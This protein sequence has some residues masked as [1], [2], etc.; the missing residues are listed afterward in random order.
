MR[1]TISTTFAYYLPI[2]AILLGVLSPPVAVG[3]SMTIEINDYGPTREEAERRVLLNAVR[4]GL[5]RFMNEQAKHPSMTERILKRLNAI[6]ADHY[7]PLVKRW[8]LDL[9]DANQGQHYLEGKVTL[10]VD[11]LKLWA[12][13]WLRQLSA[14]GKT[15]RA[16]IKHRL[17]LFIA[18]EALEEADLAAE[19]RALRKP[20]MH[21]LEQRLI[22]SGYEIKREEQKRQAQYVL[23]LSQSSLDRHGLSGSVNFTVEVFENRADGSLVTTADGYAAASLTTTSAALRKELLQR[24]AV[25]VAA[26]L[27]RKFEHLAV[28]KQTVELVFFAPQDISKRRA[29]HDLLEGLA[30][31]YGLTS[32]A[33]IDT[34]DEAVNLQI[35]EESDHYTFSFLVPD[36][37]HVRPTQL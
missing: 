20:F 2:F 34:F 36:D 11:V 25:K 8:R 21:A 15:Q 12:D 1:L 37:Y 24:A 9:D 28:A 26:E 30:A 10:D 23:Q 22:S 32:D 4:D 17:S 16:P 27:Q 18:R 35:T 3:K 5:T 13:E 31:I 19:D 6:Q 14:E 33:D 29:R 7:R